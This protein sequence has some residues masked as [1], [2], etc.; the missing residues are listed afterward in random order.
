[1][2]YTTLFF[3]LDHTLWDFEKNAYETLEELYLHYNLSSVGIENF[4]EFLDVYTAI[5]DKHWE[6]YRNGLMTKEVLRYKRFADALQHFNVNNDELTKKL[7]D[8]YIRIS[9]LKKNLHTDAIEVLTYLK[10]KYELNIITNGFNE[11]QYLKIEHS[12]LTHFFKNIITS[13][14]AGFQKPD[15]RIFEYALKQANASPNKS[16]MIGDSFDADIMGAHKAG[17][18]A[19]YFNPKK[20]KTATHPFDEI[21]RLIELNQML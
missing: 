14:K 9:P 10:S 5:N 12:G 11:V 20:Q 4:M 3:D 16:V 15:I 7:A 8:D 2:R 13:E 21:N 18:K 17:I 19:I 6:D 1:M